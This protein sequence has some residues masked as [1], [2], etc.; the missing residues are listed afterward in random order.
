MHWLNNPIVYRG[1]ISKVL[2]LL[3]TILKLNKPPPLAFL[4]INF[5][6]E[7]LNYDNKNKILLYEILN[8]NEIKIN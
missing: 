6:E 2:S 4:D 8:S 3:N 5:L 1:E 7:I